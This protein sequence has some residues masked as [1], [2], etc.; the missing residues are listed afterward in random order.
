[1]KSP[2][3]YLLLFLKGMAM[4]AADVVPGVSG[5]TIAFISGIYREL[6]DS[7]K[8]I[9]LENLRRLFREGPLA[10]WRAV[11][12]AFLLTVFGGV[13][14]SIATLARLVSYCLQQYPILL[15]SF[16]F[17]LIA[18]S[19]IYILRQLPQRALTEWLSIAVGAAVALGISLLPAVTVSDGPLLVFASGALA[20]CA[21]ILPGISGSFILLLIG[22]YPVLIDAVTG[23]DFRVLSIFVVGCACGLLAFSRVLSWLL[24]RFYSQ[25]MGTLTGFLLGSLAIVWPWKVSL[26]VMIDHRGREVV[27]SQKSLLPWDYGAVTGVD[28]QLLPAMALMLFGLCLVLG[29]EYLGSRYRQRAV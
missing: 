5:G 25:T 7:I 26:E 17:G 14:L 27:L 13:I 28:P 11:N 12:G 8:S 21:M 1:M 24:Q 3:H 6:L 19:I 15:W 16:F 10:F 20:I 2:G 23:A 22:M 29:L 9:N 4:G 18:A